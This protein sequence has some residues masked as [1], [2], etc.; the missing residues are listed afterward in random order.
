MKEI[1]ASFMLDR[2]SELGNIRRVD[3]EFQF[4]NKHY[5]YTAYKIEPQSGAPIIRIDIKEKERAE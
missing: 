2:I 1:D 5:L 3:G 4:M